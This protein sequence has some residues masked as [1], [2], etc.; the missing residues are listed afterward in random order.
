[1]NVNFTFVI[2]IINFL[3]TYVFLKRFL[4]APFASI[5]VSQEESKEKLNYIITD[6]EARL[7]DMYYEQQLQMQGFKQYCQF[8]RPTL[9]KVH[10]EEVMVIDNKKHMDLLNV[11]P[12]EPYVEQSVKII[13]SQLKNNIM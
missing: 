2:Q 12:L 13:V 9:Y 10:V 1:M 3:I 8:N 4:L 7:A 6:Q 5:I 11:Y